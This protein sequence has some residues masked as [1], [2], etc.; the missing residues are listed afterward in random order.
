MSEQ[1]VSQSFITVTVKSKE[2]QRIDQAKVYEVLNLVELETFE[3]APLT[4]ISE[5]GSALHSRLVLTRKNFKE[6]T[7]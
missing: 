6:R 2:D 5:N 4:T 1:G 7:E 3:F